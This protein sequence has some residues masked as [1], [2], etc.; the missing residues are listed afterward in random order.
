MC[1]IYKGSTTKKYK[2][3]FSFF[4]NLPQNWSSVNEILLREAIDQFMDVAEVFPV[5]Y[6]REFQGY[7]FLEQLSGRCA[8]LNNEF[9]FV[10]MRVL[11]PDQL[12]DLINKS[13][14]W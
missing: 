9:E 10:G 14:M 4:P 11:S 5:N 7:A 3:V 8:I 6:R 12:D 13:W 2:H 1:K